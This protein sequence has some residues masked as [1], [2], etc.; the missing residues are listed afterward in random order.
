MIDIF[1]HVL[2]FA[3]CIL[4]MRLSF[5]FARMNMTSQTTWTYDENP[6]TDATEAAIATS[7]TAAMAVPLWAALEAI[8]FVMYLILNRPIT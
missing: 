8:W 1:E 4:I 2:L 3:I 7:M 5:P 6:V